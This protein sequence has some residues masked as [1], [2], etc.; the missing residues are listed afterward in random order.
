MDLSSQPFN[1]KG[2]AEFMEGFQKRKG[3][4]HEYKVFRGQNTVRD[5]FRELGPVK[6]C[7]KNSSPYNPNPEKSSK[8][9]EEGTHEGETSNQEPFRVKEGKTHEQR[10][11]DILFPFNGTPLFKALQ[12]FLCV[13]WDIALKDI[14]R[15]QLAEE[16]NHLL[17]GRSFLSEPGSHLVPDLPNGSLSIHEAD[18]EVGRCV[19]TLKSTCGMVLKNIPD[20][21]AIVVAMNL[22]V[23]PESRFQPRH[24]IP[25][26]TV[27]GSGHI[28]GKVRNPLRVTGYE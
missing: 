27:E 14:H 15:M 23:A 12:K 18:Q 11:T 24:P 22:R 16:T 2:V 17:L 1:G 28:P 5:I 10:I 8:P 4:P 3:Q 25:R 20:L 13:R 6:A 26:R 19:E 7:Q 21:A 9:A